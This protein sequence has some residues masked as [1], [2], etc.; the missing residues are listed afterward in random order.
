MV[1]YLF[2]KKNKGS[3]LDLVAIT[4][5]RGR[6]HGLPGYVEYRKKCQVGDGRVTSF[7]DLS[8]NISPEVGLHVLI[9]IINVLRSSSCRTLIF[10]VECI[11]VLRTLICMLV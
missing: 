5:Q 2:F 7:E 11:Q 6:D 8:N 4:I 10:Y 1:N 3:G 9:L